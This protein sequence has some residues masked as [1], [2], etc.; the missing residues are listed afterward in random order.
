MSVDEQARPDS[1]DNAEMRPGQS[2]HPAVLILDLRFA[3]LDRPG[4]P[5]RAVWAENPLLRIAA[6][7]KSAIQN[8]KCELLASISMGLP[9]CERMRRVSAR[10]LLHEEDRPHIPQRTVQSRPC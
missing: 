9:R 10:K 3:I 8:P 4:R 2:L 7:R 1:F 6:N 5:R